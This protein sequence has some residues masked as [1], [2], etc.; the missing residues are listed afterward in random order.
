LQE[1]NK[2]KHDEILMRTIRKA[3]DENEA[4][5]LAQGSM[6]SLLEKTKDMGVPVLCSLRTGVEQIRKAFA[7]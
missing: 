5:I 6:M 3:C 4:V 2:P 1:N 7:L